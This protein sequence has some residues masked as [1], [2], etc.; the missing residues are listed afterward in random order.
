M[1]HVGQRHCSEVLQE[2]EIDIARTGQSP[3]GNTAFGMSTISACCGISIVNGRDQSRTTITCGEAA[4]A[5]T[6]EFARRS[7]SRSIKRREKTDQSSLPVPVVKRKP[8][9]DID[10]VVPARMGVGTIVNQPIICLGPV[11]LLRTH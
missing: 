6:L 1:R 11:L 2:V 5:G 3:F 4:T 8:D 7:V 9:P 10:S